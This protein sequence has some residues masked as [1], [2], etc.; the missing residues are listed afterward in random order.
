MRVMVIYRNN[1]RAD[2]NMTVF[3]DRLRDAE[4]ERQRERKRERKRDQCP[5]KQEKAEERGR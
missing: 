5:D 3:A 2:I 4:R 1:D